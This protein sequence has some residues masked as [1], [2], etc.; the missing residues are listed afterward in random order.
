MRSTW[1]AMSYSER[2]RGRKIRELEI[3]K[4]K[5]SFSIFYWMSAISILHPWLTS[6]NRSVARY[7]GP[8]SDTN[9]AKAMPSSTFIRK[10]SSASD[11]CP[12]NAAWRKNNKL[13]RS[14]HASLLSY[15]LCE[16]EFWG[17]SVPYGSVWRV[18]GG[19]ELYANTIDS[20]ERAA[21]TATGRQRGSLYPTTHMKKWRSRKTIT[22][23]NVTTLC[24]SRC[25]VKCLTITQG[26]RKNIFID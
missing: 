24:I 5:T 9:P 16:I 17:S 2:K 21:R 6:S 10:S 7:G 14:V 19:C 13:Y 25:D 8:R 20:P 4:E 18:Q 12:K 11:L 22:S 26:R 1:L 15:F 23:C 3:D